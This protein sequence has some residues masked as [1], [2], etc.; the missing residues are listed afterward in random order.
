MAGDLTNSAETDFIKHMFRTGTWTKPTDIYVALYTTMPD[1]ELGTGGT[2]VSGGSYARV[3]V[4]PSDATWDAPTSGG[5][6]ANTAAITFPAP[7][8]NWGT[9]VGFGLFYVSTAGD[10]K[11]TASLTTSKTVNSGDPAPKFEIGQLT[12]TLD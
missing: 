9:I 12:F 1:K 7:T 10:V 4:G 6:T 2:E 8:A 11:V 5:A 3:K